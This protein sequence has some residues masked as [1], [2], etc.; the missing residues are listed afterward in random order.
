MDFGVRV[1]VVRSEQE[2][3]AV[4]AVLRA[5][6]INCSYR[7]TDIAAQAFGGWQEILVRQAELDEARQFL[8]TSSQLL[9]AERERGLA[10]R[11]FRTA[12]IEAAKPRISAVA[13]RISLGRA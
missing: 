6:G 10:G 7:A 4:C 3:E 1:T 8:E 5:H 13:R 9:D 12:E 2:A 11:G